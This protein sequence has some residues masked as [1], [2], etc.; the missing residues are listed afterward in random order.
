MKSY[1]KRG[2]ALLLAAAALAVACKFVNRDEQ[3]RRLIG[4]YNL[5]P[6]GLVP[7]KGFDLGELIEPSAKAQSAA[8]YYLP[9][10]FG[11]GNA[12][13]ASGLWGTNRLAGSASITNWT[14][15]DVSTYRD[16]AMQ[17][18]VQCIGGTGANN[19]YL[20]MGRSLDPTSYAGG[21]AAPTIDQFCKLTVSPTTASVTVSTYT[22]VS[23]VSG[24]LGA[25]PY[26]WIG[27]MTNAE[28][29]ATYLTNVVLY[30]YGK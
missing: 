21:V 26:L 19:S 13:T 15:I 12:A 9:A 8:G 17:L 27:P 25:F 30:V 10:K 18:E 2:A 6:G 14:R 4:V 3:P 1:I 22:N 28:T 5:G 24:Q 23:S 11:S 16:V 7:V 29:G 20:M